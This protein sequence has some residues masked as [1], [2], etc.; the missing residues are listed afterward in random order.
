MACDISL[1]PT[2]NG[3]SKF[4]FAMITVGK[5]SLSES[6]WYMAVLCQCVRRSRM[7]AAVDAVRAGEGHG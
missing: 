1:E 4:S 5:S 3:P 6:S 2:F 7:H